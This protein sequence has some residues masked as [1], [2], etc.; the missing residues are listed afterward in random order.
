[1]DGSFLFIQSATL[2]RFM[3][4]FKP[5]T[6][7]LNPE[8]ENF[9]DAMLPINSLL[10]LVVTFCSV[11]LLGSF[12]LYRTP[13]NISCRQ[14]MDGSCLFIQSATLWRFMGAFKPFR[15]IEIIE[16]DDFNDAMLPVK[17][18]FL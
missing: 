2:W 7:R 5:F 9:N 13:L 10:V 6:L 15:L 3:G 17:S 4:A 14:Q 1:M 11:S 18:L 16:I 8:R 12:Y